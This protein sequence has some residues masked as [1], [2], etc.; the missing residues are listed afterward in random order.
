MVIVIIDDGLVGMRGMVIVVLGDVLECMDVFVVY[1][2]GLMGMLCVV[3][4]VV[5]VGDFGYLVVV[6]FLFIMGGFGLGFVYDEIDLW[7]IVGV[8]LYVLFI[9]EVFF[10]ELIFGWKEYEFEFMCDKY[11]NV[12]V[13]CLIENFDLMGVYIGD[14]IIVVLV[15][16]FID[17]EY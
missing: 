13:V 15:M 3:M 17:C 12:V 4:D 11:D 16:I 7:C 6:C 1:V 5:I 8:G 10:E 2:C 9:I 14:L